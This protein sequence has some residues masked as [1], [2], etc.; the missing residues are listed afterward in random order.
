[1]DGR[2]TAAAAVL[3]GCLLLCNTVGVG[4]EQRGGF[5]L[6]EPCG[7]WLHCAYA[8]TDNRN[9]VLAHVAAV[10]S[11]SNK[12]RC[13]DPAY[14]YAVGLKRAKPTGKDR[15]SD[16]SLEASIYLDHKC[17]GIQPVLPACNHAPPLDRAT[18]LWYAVLGGLSVF[19]NFGAFNLKKV[20]LSAPEKSKQT[21]P[22]E[23]IGV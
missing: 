7:K 1:M 23:G 21:V 14:I 5:N 17:A 6:Q 18:S 15:C 3:A 20:H 13:N 4:A 11:N 10:E 19:C 12:V 8:S 16:D 2:R 22:F 9:R